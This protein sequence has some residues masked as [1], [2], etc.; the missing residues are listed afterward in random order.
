M[1]NIIDWPHNETQSTPSLKSSDFKGFDAWSEK[2]ILMLTSHWN[3]PK[4]CTVRGTP[5]PW[6]GVTMFSVLLKSEN[7]LFKICIY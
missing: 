4:M 5:G 6:L 7:L 3:G 1:V 2:G